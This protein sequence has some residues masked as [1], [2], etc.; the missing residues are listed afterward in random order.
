M[1]G[2]SS[3]VNYLQEHSPSTCD[4]GSLKELELQD[5]TVPMLKLHCQWNHCVG[6]SQADLL[7]FTTTTSSSTISSGTLL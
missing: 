1:N 7:V 5:V 2:S 4:H 3:L 6:Q